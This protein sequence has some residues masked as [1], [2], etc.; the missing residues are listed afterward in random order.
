VK[1][2]NEGIRIANELIKDTNELEKLSKQN[3]QYYKNNL[4]PEATAE[5][6]IQTINKKGSGKIKSVR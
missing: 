2:W 5:L 4:S 6:V 1:D 3:I